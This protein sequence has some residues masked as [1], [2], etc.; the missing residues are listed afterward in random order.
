MKKFLILYK[1]PIS[2]LDMWKE[3]PEEE[4]KD[5]EGKMKEKWD[6]WMKENKGIFLETSS[7]GKTKLV[8]EDGVSDMRNDIMMYSVVNGESHESVSK[9]FTSCPHLEIPEAT[10]EVMEIKPVDDR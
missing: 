1:L 4:R 5:E 7:A 9:M 6:S 10:I 3:K 8:D 2:M